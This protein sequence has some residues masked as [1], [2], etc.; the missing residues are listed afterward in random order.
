MFP[1]LLF[2]SIS[3]HWSLKKA[4]LSLLAIHFLSDQQWLLPD[5]KHTSVTV[6][7][8]ATRTIYQCSVLTLEHLA[9]LPF[10]SSTNNCLSWNSLWQICEQKWTVRLS[11]G[12]F[13]SP[14][15][16][17]HPVPWPPWLTASISSG[18][19]V[20]TTG[21]KQTGSP[22]ENYSGYLLVH[23]DVRVKK[24]NMAAFVDRLEEL[25]R[26]EVC[27]QIN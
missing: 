8:A 18:P 23:W 24:P 26:S 2:S 14:L 6:S 25:Q 13:L 3:L 4:F 7:L 10:F 21:V 27:F 16:F 1:I 22:S 9:G 19:G 5:V 20:K 15:S 11:S 12:S 17:I